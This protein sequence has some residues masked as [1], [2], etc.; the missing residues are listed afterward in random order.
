MAE[1][2]KRSL[3]LVGCR[4]PYGVIHKP[5]NAVVS[6]GGGGGVAIS[7]LPPLWGLELGSLR[8]F[9]GSLSITVLPRHVTR[10]VG[11]AIG[12]QI[13][14]L[15]A[16]S[17]LFDGPLLKDQQFVFKEATLNSFMSLGRAAW[18]EARDTLQRVLSVNDQTLQQNA[19]LRARALVPQSSATMH[20]PAHIGDYTDFY[21]SIHH[22]TN[23]GIMFR[24][25]EN[26]LMPNWKHIPVGYHGRA[27]SVVVSGTPIRR[28]NGQT[29]PVDGEAP[30]FGP[31]R[32]M[33]FE[34]EVAFFVGG[35]PTT[36]GKPVP[37]QEAQDRIFGMVLMNDWSDLE[38]LFSN[39]YAA[40]DI[41]KWEYVPLGPFL[42]KSLGTT[43]S[44]WVVTLDALLPFAVDNMEQVPQP[45]PYLRHDDKFNFDINLTIDIKRQLSIYSPGLVLYGLTFIGMALAKYSS[46]KPCVPWQHDTTRHDTT[47]QDCLFPAER[48][49]SSTVSR[50]NYKYM[51]WTS[52][53]QLAHHT[54]TGCNLNPG[55]LMASG[56]ISGPASDSFGSML[57]LS[58]RGTK[59]VPLADGSSR[60]FLQDGDEVIIRGYCEGDSYRVGFGSCTGKLLPALNL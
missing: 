15:N 14:D 42:S 45:F 50:T 37:I 7:G 52:K 10:R 27:S 8:Q 32:L 26:A 49:V 58:W 35:P 53:Q 40:R 46:N 33:D 12:D 41:Q 39:L 16:V 57:E 11:V 9:T 23:V 51:Y 24:G 18:K 47:L 30:V 48:S 2:N 13:L 29:C 38:T 4:L 17:H 54:I 21:S 60:K 36:L 20:L 6:G 1:G 34:L 3:V 22:A 43:I 28:P 5:R 59:P 31:C 55:D 56:T 19:E 44:P 25:P